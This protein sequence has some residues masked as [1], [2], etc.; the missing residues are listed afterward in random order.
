MKKETRG[1][2]KNADP[3]VKVSWAIPAD[4]HRALKAERDELVESTGMD[5]LVSKVAY[6]WLREAM[7]KRKK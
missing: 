6:K 4:I 3:S 7:E 5:I 1:R 2:K